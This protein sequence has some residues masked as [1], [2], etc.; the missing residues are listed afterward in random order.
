MKLSDF[1]RD[2]AVF[3]VKED[4]AGKSYLQFAAIVRDRYGDSGSQVFPLAFGCPFFVGANTPHK[5]TV[6]VQTVIPG[7]LPTEPGIYFLTDVID[8]LHYGSKQ[9]PREAIA[10]LIAQVETE[11]REAGLDSS[12]HKQRAA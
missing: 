10:D 3:D 1:I 5:P 9:M 8:C 12:G 2:H 4:D 11:F 6:I 7:A